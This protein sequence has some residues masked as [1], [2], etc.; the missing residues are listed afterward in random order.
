MWNYTRRGLLDS[1]K[2]TVV[3]M[4]CMNI[5]V[6]AGKITTEEKETLIRC[7]PDP[8]PPA[9]PENARQGCS[10]LHTYS[11]RVCTDMFTI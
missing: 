8:N 7:P 3:S 11:V 4:M 1:D 5:L 9:M 6:R 2:L 10:A